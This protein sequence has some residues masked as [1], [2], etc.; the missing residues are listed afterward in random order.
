M[1]VKSKYWSVDE[2]GRLMALDAQGTSMSEMADILGRSRNSIIG[3]LDRIKGRSD[4][5]RKCNFQKRPV[6]VIIPSYIPQEAP[7][8]FKTLLEI[9]DGF[10]RWPHGDTA[11]IV[12][13]KRTD[14]Q[15]VY[16]PEH[17]EI[18]FQS[19]RKR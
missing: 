1:K 8:G 15:R 3:K 13:S 7:R 5:P 6:A 14:P 9:K 4:K 18:A 10:C 16:C 12:C 19:K 11:H 17:M 2:L